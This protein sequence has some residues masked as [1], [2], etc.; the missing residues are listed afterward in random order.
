LADRAR[1][2]MHAAAKR[3]PSGI[4]ARTESALADSGLAQG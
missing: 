3:P 1:M 4:F 2:A